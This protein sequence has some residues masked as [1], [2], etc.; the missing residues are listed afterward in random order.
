MGGWLAVFLFRPDLT[1]H[2][3][4]TA[5]GIWL[6][7]DCIW[8]FF[9]SP[10]SRNWSLPGKS[11]NLQE[12]ML[13]AYWFKS[14]KWTVF[15]CP[16]FHF[17]TLLEHLIIYS[18]LLS[19]KIYTDKHWVGTSVLSWILEKQSK[20]FQNSDV[21]QVNYVWYKYKYLDICD[22]FNLSLLFGKD[23]WNVSK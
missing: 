9:F 4:H 6:C 2:S 7:A 20:I 14:L 17:Q 19:P 10:F 23:T 13:Q 11:S 5:S 3:T 21:V 12:T 15:F 18:T 8:L 1:L 22:N 16:K